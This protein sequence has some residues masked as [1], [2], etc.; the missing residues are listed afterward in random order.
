MVKGENSVRKVA[1]GR[2]KRKNGR[3]RIRV[4]KR[5]NAGIR[6]QSGRVRG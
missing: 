2:E 5:E 1:A 6:G 4:K 3:G